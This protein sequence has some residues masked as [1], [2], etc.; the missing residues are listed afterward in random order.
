[1]RRSLLWALPLALGTLLAVAACV[2][3]VAEGEDEMVQDV[4]VTE[5][6]VVGP[7]ARPVAGVNR[8]GSDEIPVRRYEPAAG[9]EPWATLVWAHGGSFVRGTLDWP[10]ADWVA[11]SF[12]A[13]GLRVLSVDYVLA[14]DTVKAPA[15]SNDLAAVVAWAAA[16]YPAPLVVGGAS[17]GGHLAVL[18]TL[19]QQRAHPARAAAA[20]ILEYPTLHRSQRAHPQLADAVAALPEARRFRDDRITQMY[21]FYLGADAAE[22]HTPVVAGELPAGLLE[23]LPPTIIVNAD[24][25]ELRASGEQFAEQLTEAGVPVSVRIEPDTVH[26]YLNRPTESA[27]AQAQSAATIAHFVREL[28]A[29]LGQ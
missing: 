27:A 14:S 22:P 26:G 25:D 2:P 12:A 1:M 28:R 4:A 7:G 10:E 6:A 8:S 17:A 20:L 5:L 23:L 9:A 18:A 3:T 11:R 16:E 13:A 21:D 19:D 15:P 24:A 29:T